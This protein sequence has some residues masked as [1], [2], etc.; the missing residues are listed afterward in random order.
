MF[1][2]VFFSK[3]NEKNRS[4]V[5]ELEAKILELKKKQVSTVF[6]WVVNWF[7]FSLIDLVVNK[8]LKIVVTEYIEAMCP[9]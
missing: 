3:I 8:L 6:S 2:I 4:R 1:A 9:L 5:K 7:L